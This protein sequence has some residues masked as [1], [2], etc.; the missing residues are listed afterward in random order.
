MKK[1]N[2]DLYLCS[3]LRKKLLHTKNFLSSII[4]GKKTP[5]DF[6]KKKVFAI[7]DRLEDTANY[8]NT[9]SLDEDNTFSIFT[10]YNF[11][12]NSATLLDCISQLSILLG[13]SLKDEDGKTDV[14]NQLGT[15][16]AGTDKKYFEYL[17]ALCAVHPIETNRHPD[18]RDKNV[19][20]ECS[21]FVTW[22]K[23]LITDLDSD[24]IAVVYLD[25]GDNQS[26]K[27]VGINLQDI[28]NYVT[29]R[30]NLLEKIINHID[31]SYKRIIN[32]L[33]EEKLKQESDFT[34][35]CG[36]LEYLK[37]IYNQRFGE[38]E[39]YYFDLYKIIMVASF[40]DKKNQEKLIKYQNAIK[41]SVS[42]L[43]RKLQSLPNEDSFETTGLI[44]QP[45]NT[46][47]DCLFYQLQKIPQTSKFDDYKYLFSKI[48]LLQYSNHELRNLWLDR[49]KPFWGK[50]V[51][52]SP[53]MTDNEIQILMH[54]ALYFWKIENDKDF[55]SNIPSSAEYQ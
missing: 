24:L 50:Y 16:G 36:Y 1:L 42:F 29:H 38:T 8:L 55:C 4:I 25:G 21:P 51:N 19:I 53:Q 52:I 14:F 39:N 27:Y 11:I 34:N 28:L 7:V 54:V 22:R 23:Y 45:E 37:Q 32:T 26:S 10:F 17:R 9:I 35:F 30:Y 2:L 3:Q 41:Y 12:N 48:S 33:R 49:L 44:K 40:A 5:N 13:Y 15:T 43:H 31:S 46:S 20:S 47:G 18:Y 6:Y